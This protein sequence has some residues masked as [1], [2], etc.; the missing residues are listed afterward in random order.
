MLEGSAPSPLNGEVGEAVTGTRILNPE[1]V[2][3]AIPLP[4]GRRGDLPEIVVP[5]L[6]HRHDPETCPQD[7]KAKP[8]L[9]RPE[10]GTSVDR[11]MLGAA[12]IRYRRREP[13]TASRD[14]RRAGC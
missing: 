5:R 13:A 9:G 12:T 4:V 14:R 11:V 2:V 10:S 3:D 7:W 6:L 1:V 8:M